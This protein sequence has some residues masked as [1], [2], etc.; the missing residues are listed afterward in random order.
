MLRI[1][2]LTYR[3]EGR[4]LF[5]QAGANIPSGHKVGLVGR[6]GTGKTTL[7]R[8]IRGEIE[9]DGGDIT[10]PREWRIG[11][12]A[13]EVQTDAFEGSHAISFSLGRDGAGWQ[14]LGDSQDLS[15]Y[16]QLHFKIKTSSAAQFV[17][18]RIAGVGNVGSVPLAP[19]LQASTGWQD[20]TIALAELGVAAQGAVI[21]PFSIEAVGGTPAFSALVDQIYFSKP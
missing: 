1:N 12:V 8:L 20:V 7:F 21:I 11:G 6:N 15:A 5:E 13:Q 4:P 2:D 16:S 3:I 10:I 18:V 19:K 9:S 17:R 14:I